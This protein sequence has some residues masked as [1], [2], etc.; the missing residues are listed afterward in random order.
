MIRDYRELFKK[1]KHNFLSPKLKSLKKSELLQE[2]CPLPAKS[3]A[4]T[5]CT[6]D[7]KLICF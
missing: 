5:E 3:N 2:K 6:F 1:A 4:K 7:G